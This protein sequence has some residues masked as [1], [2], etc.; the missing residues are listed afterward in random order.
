MEYA[1]HI[2]VATT[3]MVN[4]GIS[5]PVKGLFQLCGHLHFTGVIMEI[6]RMQSPLKPMQP[7]TMKLWLCPIP[8]TLT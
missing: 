6:T 8:A 4:N 2:V 3:G 7:V 1:I 5:P